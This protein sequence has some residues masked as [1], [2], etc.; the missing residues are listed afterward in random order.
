MAHD[1]DYRKT[2]YKLMFS[3]ECHHGF[4]YNDG[5]NVDTVPFTHVPN[6]PGGLH[7]T[8]AKSLMDFLLYGVCKR[9]LIMRDTV[10]L[11]E[12]TSKRLILTIREIT[13]PKDAQVCSYPTEKGWWRAD[14]IIL[15]VPRDLRK[16][17]TWKW[18][19]RL[20]LRNDIQINLTYIMRWA[21]ASNYLEVIKYLVDVFILN[22]YRVY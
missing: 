18:L 14:K 6:K 3:N 17:S 1:F 12:E 20:G 9:E 8:D 21:S 5:L 15:G 10:G 2:Y 11:N 4:Q 19:L 22:D 7:F 16:P 13:I